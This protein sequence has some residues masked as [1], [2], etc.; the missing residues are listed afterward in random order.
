MLAT[1]NSLRGMTDKKGRVRPGQKSFQLGELRDVFETWCR[2]SALDDLRVFLAGWTALLAMS[3][4]ERLV[5]FRASARLDSKAYNEEHARA[6]VQK[7]R[8]ELTAGGRGE[9]ARSADT[10]QSPA[11]ATPSRGSRRAG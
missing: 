5:F 10:T 8:A 4:E 11:D 9:T 3:P 1:R 2:E 7:A 6:A